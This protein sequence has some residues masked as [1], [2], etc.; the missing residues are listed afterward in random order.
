M[1]QL[2]CLYYGY[3][4]NPKYVTSKNFDVFLIVK[5][6]DSSIFYIL[7]SYAVILLIREVFVSFSFF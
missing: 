5:Y 3:K 7:V 1:K 6:H 4:P 2:I